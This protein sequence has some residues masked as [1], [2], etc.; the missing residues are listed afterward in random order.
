VRLTVEQIRSITF[1]ALEV[2]DAGEGVCFHRIPGGLRP[3]YQSVEK[4]RVRMQCPSGVRLRFVSNTRW[5]RIGQQFGQRARE[6]FQG[7]LFV[8]GKEA[9][10]YGPGVWEEKWCQEIYRQEKAEQH[11][12]EIWLPHSASVLSFWMEVEDDSVLD[13]APQNKLRWLVYGDSFTQGM[14]A[15]FP[16][17]TQITRCARQLDA[18]VLNLSIGGAVLSKELAQ[19]LPDY[20]W[21]MAS[22]A[23]G[24]NDFID[25]N[26]LEA[27]EE[28]A[29]QLIS[30]LSQQRPGK[31]IFIQ[32]PILFLDNVSQQTPTGVHINAYRALLARAADKFPAARYIDGVKLLDLDPQYFDDDWHPNDKGVAI[33]AENLLDQ[34]KNTGAFA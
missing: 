33:Y 32:S 30:A 28:N 22:I 29:C 31:P 14:T 21:D 15:S 8:D 10:V 23:Y 9:S 12:F 34:M 13:V 26:P 16:Y 24:A 1:G 7:T 27:V 6:L 17:E 25:D 5:I 19:V 18:D 20:D 11:L 2:Q 3:I 4:F